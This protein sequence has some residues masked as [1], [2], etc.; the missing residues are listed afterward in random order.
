MKTSGVQPDYVVRKSIFG[1]YGGRILICILVC[2]ILIISAF[3][4]AGYAVLCLCIIPLFIVV[5]YIVKAATCRIEFY[6]DK[7]IVHSGLI[8]TKEKRIVLTPVMA[9]SIKYSL[10]GRIFNYGN[11]VIDTVGRWDIDT[12][13]I[14]RPE[15]LREFIETLIEKQADSGQTP[16]HM[17]VN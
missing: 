9:V 14:R 1:A 3:A 6:S 16:A 4:A 2:V 12:R 8:A 11:V 5:W 7:I 17:I 10:A 13:G 15:A